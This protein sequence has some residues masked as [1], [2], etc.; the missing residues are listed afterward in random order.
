MTLNAGE[1]ARE[2]KRKVVKLDDLEALSKEDL[3]FR[4]IQA[5]RFLENIREIEA[6]MKSRAE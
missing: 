1:M 6:E 5:S 3:R 4:F 2:R